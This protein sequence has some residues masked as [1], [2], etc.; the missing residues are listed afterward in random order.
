MD[1]FVF[2]ELCTVSFC[3]GLLGWFWLSPTYEPGSS[4]PSLSLFQFYLRQLFFL[5]SASKNLIAHSSIK[6][7]TNSKTFSSSFEKGALWRMKNMMDIF[8]L[9]KDRICFFLQSWIYFQP[10][11]LFSELGIRVIF[12]FARAVIFSGYV[13][14]IKLPIIPFL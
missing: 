6:F 8:L 2:L 1:F 9:I 4:N 5:Y 13:L 14:H 10:F 12:L 7:G 3:R 11:L